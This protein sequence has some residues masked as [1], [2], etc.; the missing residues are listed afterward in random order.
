MAHPEIA[1]SRDGERQVLKL[2]HRR[3][4]INADWTAW[5]PLWATLAANAMPLKQTEMGFSSGF[6]GLPTLNRGNASHQYL[7]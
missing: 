4:M 1:F 6:G 5:T 2:S 3:G 7:L